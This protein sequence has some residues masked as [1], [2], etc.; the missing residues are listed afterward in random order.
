MQSVGGHDQLIVQHFL[1]KPLR[2]ILFGI[3]YL[4]LFEV[5]PNSNRF[6]AELCRSAAFG[7]CIE[8]MSVFI[9]RPLLSIFSDFAPPPGGRKQQ[10][11]DDGS[12]TVSDVNIRYSALKTSCLQWLSDTQGLLNH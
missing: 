10:R 8:I 4:D 7:E 1:T 12:A 2:R 3:Q 11:S 9:G 5:S 6:E